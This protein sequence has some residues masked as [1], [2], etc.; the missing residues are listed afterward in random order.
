MATKDNV[1][2]RSYRELCPFVHRER[3]RIYMFTPSVQVVGENFN[4]LKRQRTDTPRRSTLSF[5]FR[6]LEKSR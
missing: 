6:A 1:C 2:T 3:V 4:R 5:G